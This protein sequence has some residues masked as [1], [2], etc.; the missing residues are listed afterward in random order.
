MLEVTTRATLER[1]GTSTLYEAQGKQGAVPGNL[2]PIDPAAFLAGTA[3]TVRSRPGDNLA[4]HHAVLLAEEGDVLII[5]CGGYSD[6]GVWGEAMTVAAQHRGISGLVVDGSVRDVARITELGFPVFSRGISMGGTTKEDAGV[7][8]A[9][10]AWGALYIETGDIVV[11]DADGVVLIK[12]FELDNVVAAAL[13]RE[14]NEH[15]MFEAIR[16]GKTTVELMGLKPR[17]GTVKN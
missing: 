9:P 14:G 3:L 17:E 10:L 13:E 7:I 2:R 11:G 8:G 6:C 5:D 12:S 16:T 1:L 4:L 15:A